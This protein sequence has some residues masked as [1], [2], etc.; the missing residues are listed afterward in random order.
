M[1]SA[2]QLS[3]L[4]GRGFF[5]K[6]LPPTFTTATFGAFC[7]AYESK[8]LSFDC[9][10]EKSSSKPSMFYLARAGDLRRDLSILNPIHYALLCKCVIENWPAIE[11]R[12]QS[13]I[14]STTPRVSLDGRAIERLHFLDSIPERRAETRKLGRFLLKTDISRFYPS[15]YTHSIPWAFHSK[16]AA[17]A[18]RTDAL[19]G[20]VID[21]RVR[22]CQDG[23]TIGI[24]VGPDVSLVIAESILAQVD[25]EISNLGL[26]V[27]RHMDDYEMVFQTEA[28]ALKARALLQAS[29]IGFELNLNP[30]KTAIRPLPQPIEDPWVA[31]LN[32][33]QIE[34]EP[35]RQSFKKDL[36]RYCDTAFKLASEHP[37]EGILKYA[38]GRISKINPPSGS[39]NLVANL[40][41]QFASNEPGCLGIA[42]RPI[43]RRLNATPKQVDEE[44][45]LLVYIIREH[46][47]QRNSSEVSWAIWAALVLKRPLPA[48]V[49]PLVFGMN[50]S[51]CSLLLL[52]ARRLRLIKN[53][54]AFA[55]LRKQLAKES[56]YGARWLLLYE[57]VKK[58]WLKFSGTPHP[59]TSDPNFK[60]LWKMDVEFYDETKIDLPA[61]KLSA[62]PS[63][64]L[65]DLDSDDPRLEAIDDYLSGFV[66]EYEEVDD[67]EVEDD[68]AD[69]EDETNEDLI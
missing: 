65:E 21:K 3:A 22:N 18:D 48:D 69:D 51:V 36:I 47:P 29:L 56:L 61:P 14:S 37:N 41:S 23:Q 49:A 9:S 5:P 43:L 67:E 52:H 35:W 24:P 28:E 68:W 10:K 12:F 66:T 44:T 13:T 26:G 57:S 8:D 64:D 38:A 55:Q 33:I 19:F 39:E 63:A 27:F 50:E 7:A 60:R 34:H 2:P 45:N 1:S 20:N 4:T 6:E 32:G 42:L 53:P 46:A 15:I 30:S 58:G 11:K 16:S 62:D 54:S 40:L 25:R 17:K 59:V 31:E